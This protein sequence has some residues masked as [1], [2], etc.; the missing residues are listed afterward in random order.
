MINPKRALALVVAA[1]TATAL[2]VTP[3]VAY[4]SHS[5]TGDTLT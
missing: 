1:T 5:G 2:S 4:A 3:T